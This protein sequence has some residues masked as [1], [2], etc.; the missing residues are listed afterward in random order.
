MFL[1]FGAP[2]GLPSYSGED[3]S[4]SGLS[5]E[6]RSPT[7]RGRSEFRASERGRRHVRATCTSSS[8]SMTFVSG[9][10]EFV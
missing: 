7:L 3:I 1:L 2:L 6:I 5:S 8:T 4:E 10:S 9:T